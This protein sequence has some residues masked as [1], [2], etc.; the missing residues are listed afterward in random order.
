VSVSHRL[1]RFAPWLLLAALFL[2]AATLHARTA[3]AAEA[4]EDTVRVAVEATGARYAGDCA[5]TISP[6][7][8]GAVCSKLAGEQGTT[9]AYM[10]GRTFSEFSR[11]LFVEQTPS[12]WRL[13]GE[14]PLSLE[15]DTG[16]IPWPR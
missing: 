1:A 7:D 8:V 15:T 16:E 2:A 4:A 3:F 11:W 5:R 6:R 13:S 10:V 12:G 14:L 9:R